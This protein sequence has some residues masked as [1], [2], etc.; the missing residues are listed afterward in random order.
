MATKHL[1][2]A[3]LAALL[4]A[5]TLA[6]SAHASPPSL[7]GPPPWIPEVPGTP[8][9]GTGSYIY[10]YIDVPPPA[11]VDA[12]GVNIGS[13]AAPGLTL[14]GLPGSRLGN[15]AHHANE[16]TSANARYGIAAGLAPPPAVAPGPAISAG[17]VAAGLESPDGQPPPPATPTSAPGALENSAGSP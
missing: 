6:A 7:P 4:S 5:L 3:G 9:Q 2:T 15:S 11:M 14:D 16:L 8:Y 12:R 17:A 10:N 13:N 1:A